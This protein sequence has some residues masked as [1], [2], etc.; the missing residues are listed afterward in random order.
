F[1]LDNDAAPGL[2]KNLGDVT[3]AAFDLCDK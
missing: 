3:K 1:W 2:K